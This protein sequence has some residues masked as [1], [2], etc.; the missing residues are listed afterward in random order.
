MLAALLDLIV[1]AG[2]YLL[3][4]GQASTD[5]VVAAILCGA[6]ATALSILLR[7]FAQRSFRFRGVPWPRVLGR[8][9]LALA[10]DALRVGRVLARAAL[11]GPGAAQGALDLAGV[12]ARRGER[13]GSGAARAG[14]AR[15]LL[16]AERL[17][18]AAAGHARRHP[19][20]PPCRAR[21]VAGSGV[22]DMNAWLIAV[23]ALLPALLV[24]VLGALRGNLLPRLVAVQLATGLATMILALMTFAFDQSSFMDPALTLVLLSFPGTLALALFLERW[25]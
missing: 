22:A 1:F 8:P 18:A 13:R 11:L 4:A 19:A 12:P 14:H 16:R 7:R 20:A 9:L 10:P 15:Q 5:E 2:A 23:I 24:P 25:L 6:A 3:F 21:A 17:R